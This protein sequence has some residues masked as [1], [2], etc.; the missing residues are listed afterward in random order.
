MQDIKSREELIGL[1]WEKGLL[2]IKRRIDQ[3]ELL[4]PVE[5]HLGYS[6]KTFL[7][8]DSVTI[9]QNY[10]AHFQFQVIARRRRSMGADDS[11]YWINSSSKESSDW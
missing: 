2:C 8:V 10:S 11:L 6:N 4:K 1:L 3:F 9:N 5:L 7:L